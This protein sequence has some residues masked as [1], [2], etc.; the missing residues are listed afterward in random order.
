MTE[1]LFMCV[2]AFFCV[3]NVNAMHFAFAVRVH[4][5]RQRGEERDYANFGFFG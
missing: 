3:T 4:R 5:P 1:L 2:H